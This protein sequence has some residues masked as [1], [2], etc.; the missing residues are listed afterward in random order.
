MKNRRCKK[1]N[2]VVGS[3][4]FKRNKKIICITL[5]TEKDS[6]FEMQNEGQSKNVTSQFNY[7]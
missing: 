3:K 7:S 2:E 4:V 5:D 6:H 1:I